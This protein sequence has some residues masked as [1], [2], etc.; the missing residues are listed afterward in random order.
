MNEFVNN[1]L[2]DIMFILSIMIMVFIGMTI[3]SK[4][5]LN[6]VVYGVSAAGLSFGV[7]QFLLTRVN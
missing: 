5:M 7:I 3:M 6:R 4:K 2:E 1:N